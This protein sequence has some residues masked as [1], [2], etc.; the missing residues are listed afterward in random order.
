VFTHNVSPCDDGDLCTDNDLCSAGVCAGG[1]ISCDD[2]EPCTTDGC[3]P[4]SGCTHDPVADETPCGDGGTWCEAGVCVAMP[5]QTVSFDTLNYN[6]MTGWPLDF[7][8]GPDCGGNTSQ[9]QMDALCEL[10]GYATS[11]SRESSPQSINICY[12]W[13]ACTDY[14]WHSN[15]CSGQQTQTMITQVTCQQ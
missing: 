8:A 2:E 3:E 9:E 7:D 12:C 5:P 6:G 1:S 10:A 14:T 4:A 13:G 15:C 11:T